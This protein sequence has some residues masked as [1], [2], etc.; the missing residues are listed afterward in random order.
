MLQNTFGICAEKI[1]LA[2][3]EVWLFQISK[4]FFNFLSHLYN[5]PIGACH[6][7]CSFALKGYNSRST[8]QLYIT[9]NY[10]LQ[11]WMFYWQIYHALWIKHVWCAHL[12]SWLLIQLVL[13]NSRIRLH[14]SLVNQTPAFCSAMSLARRKRVWGLWPLDRGTVECLCHVQVDREIF[15]LVYYVLWASFKPF[16]SLSSHTR[17]IDSLNCDYSAVNF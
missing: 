15:F 12:P 2:V 5:N 3:V 1:G 4:H 16:K 9:N 8:L 6:V 10:W 11:I 17:T 7:T 13:Q 14:I